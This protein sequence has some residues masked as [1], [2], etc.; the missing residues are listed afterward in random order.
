MH[1][2]PSIVTTLCSFRSADAG[3][4]AF[5]YSP[6][7]YWMRRM[8]P[9]DRGDPLA[10]HL[11]LP[12]TYVAPKGEIYLCFD[13][14]STRGDDAPSVVRLGP[15]HEAEDAG[16]EQLLCPLVTDDTPFVQ[17][18]KLTIVSSCART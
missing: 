7:L 16:G 14:T 10:F 4:M 9:N 5:R 3:S 18:T 11:R 15:C 2:S 1:P 17:D 12:E 8:V 13:V 6:F